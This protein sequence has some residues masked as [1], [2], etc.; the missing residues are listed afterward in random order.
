MLKSRGWIDL[1][2]PA[3]EFAAWLTKEEAELKATLT[4]T[5]MMK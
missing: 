5:G 2:Q 3:D 1:Y 4:E